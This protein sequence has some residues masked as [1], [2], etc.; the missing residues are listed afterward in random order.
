MSQ[1]QPKYVSDRV[2]A[3]SMI[4]DASQ[5]MSTLNGARHRLSEDTPETANILRDYVRDALKA[6]TAAEVL[7]SRRGEQ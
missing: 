5:A 6:L 2:S 1:P 7:L 3:E 4:D